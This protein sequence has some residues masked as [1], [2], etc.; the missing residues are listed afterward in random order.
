MTDETKDGVILGI[1]ASV[2]ALLVK[3][4]GNWMQRVR[5]EP[6][7]LSEQNIEWAK[8]IMKRMENQVDA[9]TA[10]VSELEEEIEN[11]RHERDEEIKKIR[12]EHA[13]EVD[14]IRTERM[15]CEGKYRELLGRMHALTEKMGEK[16]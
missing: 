8:D 2:S 12:E 3:L 16:L 13:R 10:R 9:L 4:A 6:V 11:L 1:G 15:D 7:M 14:L 5:R